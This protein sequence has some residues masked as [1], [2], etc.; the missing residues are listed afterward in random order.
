[1]SV[2]LAN[3][4]SNGR[5]RLASLGQGQ[6]HKSLFRFQLPYFMMTIA[7]PTRFLIVPPRQS[8]GNAN[9]NRPTHVP[10]GI[11]SGRVRKYRTLRELVRA[12]KTPGDPCTPCMAAQRPPNQLR[13]RAVYLGR[14]CVSSRGRL[15]TI[16]RK[17]LITPARRR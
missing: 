7:G 3:N 6:R 5:A 10:P 4:R 11:C 2:T 17:S 16:G 12:R 14:R 9:A 13:S 1:M 8:R 15:T